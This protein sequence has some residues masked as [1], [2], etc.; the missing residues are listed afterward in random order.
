MGFHFTTPVFV[1]FQLETHVCTMHLSKLLYNKDKNAG[2]NIWA[3][4]QQ[5]SD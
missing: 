4:K 1:Y 5:N 2:L 3:I